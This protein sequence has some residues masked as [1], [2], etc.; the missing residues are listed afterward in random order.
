MV[1]SCNTLLFGPFPPRFGLH[2]SFLLLNELMVNI[3]YDT[4]PVQHFAKIET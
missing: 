2:S 3:F 4:N 1:D